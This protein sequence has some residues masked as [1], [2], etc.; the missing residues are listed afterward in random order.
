MRMSFK[1]FLE[2]YRS[3]EDELKHGEDSHAKSGIHHGIHVNV[4]IHPKSRSVDHGNRLNSDHWN[5]IFSRAANHAKD[6]PNT[7]YLFYSKKHQQGFVGHWMPHKKQ[8]D[9]LTILP[10]GRRNPKPDT[11]LHMME[12]VII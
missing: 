12:S 10:K 7:H 2:S 6:K 11:K 3:K 4:L 1:L 8:M 9:V 5:D